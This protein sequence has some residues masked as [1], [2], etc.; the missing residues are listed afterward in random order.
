MSWPSGES[1]ICVAAWNPPY[2]PARGTTLQAPL[3]VG[4]SSGIEARHPRYESLPFFLET[5]NSEAALSLEA[6]PKAIPRWTETE[7]MPAKPETP[8]FAAAEETSLHAAEALVSPL[9]QERK[10]SCPVFR[11]RENVLIA[12]SPEA[13]A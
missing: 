9:M 13:A 1:R 5:W 12:E 7:S 3:P 4:P 2:W 8:P 6:N 10:R 11:D